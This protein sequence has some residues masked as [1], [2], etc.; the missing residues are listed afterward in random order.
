MLVKVPVASGYK[1][2][3]GITGGS[4]KGKIQMDWMSTHERRMIKIAVQEILGSHGTRVEFT[5][6]FGGYRQL[7]GLLDSIRCDYPDTIYQDMLRK[8]SLGDRDRTQSEMLHVLYM[9]GYLGY[10]WNDGER[11]ATGRPRVSNEHWSIS[12]R[13]NVSVQGAFS[14]YSAILGYGSR[15]KNLQIR[16]LDKPKKIKKQVELYDL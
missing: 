2:V 4:K 14:K 5:R 10:Y 12:P 7:A 11:I 1:S 3:D 9:R 8:H 13:L 6:D 16:T 15:G